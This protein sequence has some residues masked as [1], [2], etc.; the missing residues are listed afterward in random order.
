MNVNEHLWEFP[1]T[2]T[3]KVM[4]AVDAPLE[5]AVIDILNLHLEE[6]D[7]SNI[8]IK[9]SSKGNYVSVNALIVVQHKEQVEK[10][11]AALNSSPHVKIVF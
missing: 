2:M 10:I 9:P 7:P 4:G 3:L 1:H 8:N 6:F 5:Q 11:Y